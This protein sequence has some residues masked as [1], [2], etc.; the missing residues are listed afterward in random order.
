MF[1]CISDPVFQNRC[2]KLLLQ[3][4][5]TMGKLFNSCITCKMPSLSIL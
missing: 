4:A 5:V 1:K 3:K 2:L